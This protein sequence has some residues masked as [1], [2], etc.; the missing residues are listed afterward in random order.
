MNWFKKAKL[1]KLSQSGEWWILDGGQAVFADGDISDMSHVGYL[2]EHAQSMISEQEPENWEMWKSEVL[3]EI[4]QKKKQELE[5]QKNALSDDDPQVDA[6]SDVI[7][8]Q[9]YEIWEQERNPEYYAYDLIFEN[10][11]E[12]GID[13]GLFNVAEGLDNDPRLYGMKLLGWKRVQGSNVE[14][15]SL[16]PGDLSDIHTGMEDILDSEGYDEEADPELNI[17]VHSTG[18]WYSAPLSQV[19]TGEFLS[20][21]KSTKETEKAYQRA[22][23]QI[24]KPSNSYYSSWGD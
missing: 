7:D 13:P 22:L 23:N 17:Y 19:K 10:A 4:L 5:A 12:L 21:K 9:L 24:D 18:K 14:T 1:E 8:A 6:K 20:G 3:S 15:W 2:I 11:E 16:Q